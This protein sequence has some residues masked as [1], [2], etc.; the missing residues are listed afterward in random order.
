ML[1]DVDELVVVVVDV[2][3]LVLEVAV[4]L[5]VVLVDVELL[6]LA[7]VDVTV[8]VELVGD[9]VVVVVAVVLVGADGQATAV[10]WRTS[11]T[12]VSSRRSI[13]PAA[14]PNVTQ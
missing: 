12:C 11:Q 10:A 13:P 14:P 5:V 8:V 9:E 7:V 1:V 2:E 3:L 4:E 6:V